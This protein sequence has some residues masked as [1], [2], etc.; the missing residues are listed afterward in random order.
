MSA[1]KPVQ[2]RQVPAF[3]KPLNRLIRRL[4]AGRHVYALLRHRG[5]R[6]GRTFETPVMAWPTAG[7]MLIPLSWG[8]E[9]D[10][11]RNLVAAQGC[12]VQVQGHW[13]RCGTPTLIQR[14]QA[15]S[16][17]P[18]FTRTLAGLFPV[19]Q[20]VLLGQVEPLT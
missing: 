8:A 12:E 19:Q 11:Y 9:A 5:R 1:E 16:Y 18:A 2:P 20:F 4:V 7:G 3:F 15:L 10:W 6:S 17:L 14:A 13:Y